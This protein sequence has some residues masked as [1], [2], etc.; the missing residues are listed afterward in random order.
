MPLNLPDPPV[1]VCAPSE[2]PQ[3]GRKSSVPFSKDVILTIGPG[4]FADKG[5]CV[6]TDLTYIWA[7]RGLD[8][9]WIV[10]RNNPVYHPVTQRSSASLLCLLDPLKGGRSFEAPGFGYLFCRQRWGGKR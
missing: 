7:V 6:S 9:E 3:A 2:T 10:L 4:A 5:D 1:K 8:V